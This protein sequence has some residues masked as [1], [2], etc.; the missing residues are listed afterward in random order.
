MSYDDF[1]NFIY[2]LLLKCKLPFGDYARF[3]SI[4]DI[5]L[6]AVSGKELTPDKSIMVFS[7]CVLDTK[8]RQTYRF[9]ESLFR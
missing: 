4:T 1:S 3:K 9:N 5:C 2:E 7:N 6:K 8:T